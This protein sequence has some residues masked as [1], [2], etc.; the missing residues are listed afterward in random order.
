MEIFIILI[1]PYRLINKPCVLNNSLIPKGEIR[2]GNNEQEGEL[3][4]QGYL[5]CLLCKVK[6]DILT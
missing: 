5:L 4:M 2:N 6:L 1:S 3:Y